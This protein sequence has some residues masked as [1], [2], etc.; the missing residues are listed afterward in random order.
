MKFKHTLIAGFL[1]IFSASIVFA[2]YY[3]Y[4]DKNGIKHYTDNISE[5]PENQRP[6]LTIH[7]SIQPPKKEAAQKR[8]PVISLE[9]LVTKK[10]VL[11]K[12]YEA[13]I[14]KRE[15]LNRQKKAIGEKKYNELA[16]QLNVKIRQYQDKTIAYE[17]L[18][19][20]YN[21]QIKSVEKK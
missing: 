11:D 4:T 12:E 15:D 3:Q 8:K 2:E 16:T 5:I 21:G 6:T 1:F 19:K 17:A 20:K 14:Q 13:L 10:E 9:S 18:V 7:E